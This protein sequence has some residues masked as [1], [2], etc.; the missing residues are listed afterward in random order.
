MIDSPGFLWTVA[1]FILL[2]GPLVF[3]HELGHFFV[4]RF[5]GVKVDVFS[6]GFGREIL[7]RTDRYGT[8]WK[9]GWIP[10]GGYVRFAGDMNGASM[11]DKRWRD[12]PPEERT[13]VFHAKPV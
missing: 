11:E 4:A 2:I 5:F 1:C 7:G 8:R 10:L 13:R 9:F 12:L 3:V 6:I